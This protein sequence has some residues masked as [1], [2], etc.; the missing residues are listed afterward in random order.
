MS[1]TVK[2]IFWLVIALV[3]L[4][5]AYQVFNSPIED[6]TIQ[7]GFIGPLTG[8]VSDRGES[9]RNVISMAFEEINNAGGI[10]DKKIE[11]TYEDGG[12]NGQDAASAMKKLA[13]NEKIK[14]VIGGLCDSESLAA[15]LIAE[16]NKILLLS[17]GS[18]SAELTNI[19][20]YFARTYPSNSIQGSVLS[21]IAY[22][23]KQWKK[24]AFIQE[25]LDYPLSIF[26]AFK[27]SFESMGGEVVKEEFPVDTSDFSSAL[28]KLKSEEPDAVF[29]N[30]ETAVIIEMILKQIRDLK[31]ELPLLVTDVVG[32]DA[33]IVE[34]NSE[35]LEGALT[36]ELSVSVSNEKFEQLA[37]NYEL[38]YKEELSFQGYAQ[39]EYDTVFMIKDAI[40]EVGYDANKIASWFRSV[41]DWQGASG[42]ITLNKDGDRKGGYVPKIILDGKAIELKQDSEE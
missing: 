13:K 7:I 21:E 3:V 20:K 5:L 2:I 10:D 26:E 22:K 11:V 35:L 30:I 9:A 32:N 36:A 28:T 17:P 24:V 34:K 37:K 42:S 1:R 27:K 23:D 12:C 18:S 14:V 40:T 25:Q 33:E 38:K 29:I 16:E 19:S 15:V 41:K 39:V 31:W 8:E 4:L 6:D